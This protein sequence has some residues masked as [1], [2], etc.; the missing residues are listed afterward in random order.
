MK[1]RE[2]LARCLIGGSVLGI[3]GKFFEIDYLI[4]QFY[5][6]TEGSAAITAKSYYRVVVL[7]DPHL[8][9]R[10]REVKS[11]D[12][13]Q[14]IIEA[15][16][17]VVQDMNAWDDVDEVAVLGDI[18]AQFGIESEYNF[19]RQYFSRLQKPVFL[20][21]GNHDYIYEDAFS[22]TGKFVHGSAETRKCK[23][24]QFQETFGLN[25][26]YY[27]HQAGW[28]QL[29]YLSPDSLT[30]PYL[31]E[32]SEAQVDWLNKELAQ[33]PQKPTIIFFHA[34]L[35]DTLLNY[36]KSVNTPNFIT[37]PEKVINTVIK[38]NSQIVLWVSGH[39]H[40][41]ASNGSYASKAVNTYAEHVRN[42]HTPDMDRE[43]IWTNSLYLYD[44][45]IVIRTYNHRTQQWEEALDR[46]IDIDKNGHMT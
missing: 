14:R 22:E 27:S 45:K 2:F 13:Q 46:T 42:I 29:I 6:P 32:M 19:A 17:K 21:N 43:T 35:K 15:K 38:N 37:Q 39:T 28:Y 26:L 34:P 12:K 31:T 41:P 18:A 4:R 20:I 16:N 9:V 3:T 8:P 24:K 40:T 25:S 23:L 5:Q 44:D 10:G 7:G 36:N 33:Y 1:R 11:P 30:S